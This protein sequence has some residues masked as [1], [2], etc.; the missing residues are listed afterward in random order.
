MAELNAE[1]DELHRRFGYGEVSAYKDFT[2]RF[3]NHHS[4]KFEPAKGRSFSL[5]QHQKGKDDPLMKEILLK[6]L[7]GD[8]EGFIHQDDLALIVTQSFLREFGYADDAPFVLMKFMA[9]DPD[10]SLS[11]PMPVRTVVAQI[12]GK[13]RFAFTLKFYQARTQPDSHYA[14]N[15]FDIRTKAHIHLLV[16]GDSLLAAKTQRLI[17]EYLNNSP[18]Q[19]VFCQ[20]SGRHTQSMAQGYDL[21]LL[22]TDGMTLQQKQKLVSGL[23]KHLSGSDAETQLIQTYD[24]YSYDENKQLRNVIAYDQLSVHFDREL[25]SVR[26]FANYLFS[27]YNDPDLH[28]ESGAIEVDLTQVIEKENFNFLS[29]LAFIISGLLII[30][31]TVSIVLFIS[32]LIKMHLAKVQMNIGTYKAFGL[33]NSAARNIYFEIIS[34]FI[35]KALGIGLLAALLLGSIA[36][37]FMVNQLESGESYFQ[38]HHLFT[39]SM[40]LI[41]LVSTLYVSWRII[42]SML[43]KSP[44]DLIYNR[45]ILM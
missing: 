37:A 22:G 42:R 15:T 2:T 17:T 30:L 44:G 6:T 38:L 3:F 26:A 1:A 31:A 24:Y 14:Q 11:V 33:V 7:A 10:T 5:A 43:S 35:G 4:Q 9:N 23:N 20:Y 16:P 12:P 25:D 36:N 40:T 39:Y 45:Q 18:Y 34:R 27:T 8:P 21:F 41:L 19:T 13:N 29:K 32:N 28:R